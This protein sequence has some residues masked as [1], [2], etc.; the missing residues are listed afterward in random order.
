MSLIELMV[1]VAIGLFLV[2]L[3]LRGFAASLGNSR[4]NS[5]VSEY[6]TNG[7]YALGVLKREIRHAALSPL[8]WDATQLEINTSVS[9]RDFGCGAGV[10]N[11]LM[12]AGMSASN[13]ANP[14]SASCLLTADDREFLRGDV[15]AVRRLS[16]KP[17]TSFAAN[18]PY[19]RVS[20]GAG[21]MFLGGE[22]PIPLPPPSF[23]YAA[24]TDVFYINSFTQSATEVPLVPALYRLRLSDGANPTMVPELVASNIE[25]LQIQFAIDDGSGKVRYVNPGGVTDWR[26]VVSARIWLLV[27]AS[28]REVGLVSGSYT[29]AD[30]TYTP[31]DNFRRVV[32][33][34]TI[35]LRNQGATP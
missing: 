31:N 32:L 5:L 27:R 21:H 34:S 16:N 30:V 2:T 28:E 7:R 33:S 12:N 3:L 10:N 6:Q 14:W 29:M 13:D 22:V 4:T 24:L 25:H 26:S 18:A 15:V 17:V 8:L 23:D 20:Y 35:Q 1:G 11:L 9:S 19:V